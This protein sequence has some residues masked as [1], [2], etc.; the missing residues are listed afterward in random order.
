[1]FIIWYVSS[2]YN[3]RCINYNKFDEMLEGVLFHMNIM[4]EEMLEKIL[5]EVQDIK[6]IVQE[7]S[8]DIECL[9]QKE[10]KKDS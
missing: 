6:V 8:D 2:I 5:R 3:F 4:Q 7:N 10:D 9:L 1:M